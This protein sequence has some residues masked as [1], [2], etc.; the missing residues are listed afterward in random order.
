VLRPE[1]VRRRL[2]KLEEYIE[3]LATIQRY[4]RDEFLADPQR[5]GSAERFLQLAIECVNDVSS[6]VA[7]AKRL[8]P[9]EASR[10]LPRLFFRDGLIDESLAQ[11]WTRMIG[12]RNILVHNYLEIDR[13]IVYDMLNQNLGD[14]QALARAFSKFIEE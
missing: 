2:E 5:Y 11:R 6:H 3:I 1:V 14:F 9:V 13:D 8:G 4:D 10:D 12:F 7:A